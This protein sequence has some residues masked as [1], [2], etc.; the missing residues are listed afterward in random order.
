MTLRLQSVLAWV[1]FVLTLAGAVV[2][3]LAQQEFDAL[4]V[5]FVAMSLVGAVIVWR[6]GGNR[7]GW[8]MVA[9]GVMALSSALG[10]V[11]ADSGSVP[12]GLLVL[13]ALAA[14]SMFVATLAG[15]F[16]I[17]PLLFPTG[18]P[19]TPRWRW[20]GWA[21]LGAV[22]VNTAL[23]VIQP[24]VAGGV[25]N[26]L[27]IPGAP[28]PENSAIGTAVIVVVLVCMVLAAASLVVRF[29]RASGVERKQVAW[30]TYAVAV[31]A[32]TLVAQEFA[33]ILG[34]EVPGWFEDISFVLAI[35]AFPV[36]I[37]IA[38]LRYRLYDIGRLVRRTVSYAL[39]ALLLAAV[40]LAGIAALGAVV[41]RES[42][43]AVAAA[44]LGAAA[45]FN[46]V[47][48]RV[49]RWI[50]RRFD[51][52][53]YDAQMVVEQ[54]SARRRGEV[55]LDGLAADLTGVVAAT[56]RPNGVSLVLVGERA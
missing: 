54:F 9:I 46:P 16:V 3:Q 32:V 47:R 8:V 44:T 48:R 34:L 39:V 20:V 27:G 42:P 29:R 2:N 38:V 25:P 22:V 7:V 10:G 35:S 28:G 53:R 11:V 30:L 15:T 55:D 49:Q 50:D 6:T 56:L 23:V 21:A 14:D 18:R 17:L 31:I 52:A 19:P 43:L 40:Y 37:G 1:L 24:T 36:A 13:A 33:P 5:P 51:R 4:S 12:E 26:P 45:L 41:G